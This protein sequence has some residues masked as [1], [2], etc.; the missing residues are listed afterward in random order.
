MH[1]PEYTPRRGR[2]LAIQVDRARLD[3]ASVTTVGRGIKLWC[4]V[5]GVGVV[6]WG[7][8]GGE[9]WGRGGGLEGNPKPRGGFQGGGGGGKVRCWLSGGVKVPCAYLWAANSQSANQLIGDHHFCTALIP[10]FLAFSQLTR[11][12][13]I[14]S[15]L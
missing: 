2:Y 13:S 6:G 5:G 11:N 7:G 9:G 4:F 12:R 8:G 14:T 10:C 1:M 15:A 3:G